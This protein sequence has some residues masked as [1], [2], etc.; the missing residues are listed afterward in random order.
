M[1]ESKNVSLLAIAAKSISGN[2]LPVY[3]PDEA[4]GEMRESSVE[5]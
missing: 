4:D 1:K 5:L 3:L 2:F